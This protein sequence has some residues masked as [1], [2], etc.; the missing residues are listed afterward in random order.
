MVKEYHGRSRLK[1]HQRP[2]SKED[3]GNNFSRTEI[4]GRW[5]TSVGINN[6]GLEYMRVSGEE[7]LPIAVGKINPSK[8][9]PFWNLGELM[10]DYG[11]GELKL[12]SKIIYWAQINFEPTLR[13]IELLNDLRCWDPWRGGIV[14]H[15]TMVYYLVHHLRN[16]YTLGRRIISDRES[17][18]RHLDMKRVYFGGHARTTRA[19][20]AP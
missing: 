18:G 7:K 14:I 9:L 4:A 5:L 19:E 17:F 13:G 20:L 8:F 11:H 10:L 12:N 16:E 6:E 3:S 1:D 2:R 15:K